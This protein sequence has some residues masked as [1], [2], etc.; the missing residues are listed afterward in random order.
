MFESLAG[1]VFLPVRL[2]SVFLRFYYLVFNVKVLIF[3]LDV[4]VFLTV[5]LA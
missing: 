4:C 5:V 1:H 3:L 2:L